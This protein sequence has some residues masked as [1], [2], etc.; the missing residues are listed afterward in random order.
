MRHEDSP[1]NI[2]ATD[3]LR[4]AAEGAAQAWQAAAALQRGDSAPA[5]LLLRGWRCSDRPELRGAL[6]GQLEA[7]PPR[8]Q[9]RPRALLHGPLPALEG[10]RRPA[11]LWRE[12]LLNRLPEL[13]PATDP[14]ERLAWGLAELGWWGGQVSLRERELWRE[15][16]FAPDAEA[17]LRTERLWRQ[18]LSGKLWEARAD[19]EELLLPE[20]MSAFRAALAAR[21]VPLAERAGLLRDFED[22][23][24]WYIIGGR[25][26]LPGWKELALRLLEMR[27]E[28]AI[29]GVA[30]QL[31]R[32]GLAWTFACEGA[33]TPSWREVARALPDLPLGRLGRLR[34]LLRQAEQD[35]GWL[36]RLLDLK[37]CLR[38]LAA[39]SEEAPRLGMAQAWAVVL[40]HRSRTRGRLRAVLGETSAEAL[41][42]GLIPR[43][44]LRHRTA[45]ALR[46]YAWGRAHESLRGHE[47]PDWSEG[48]TPRCEAPPAL[49]EPI[50]TPQRSALVT[51]VL[52]VCLRDRLDQ[53]LHWSRSGRWLRR[54]DSGWGRLLAEQLPADMQDRGGGYERLRLALHHEL[55]SALAELR[56]R[57]ARL[58]ALRGRPEARTATMEI[59]A[60]GWDPA[61]PRIQRFQR[62]L[63]EAAARSWELCPEEASDEP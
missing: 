29:D 48:L 10:P 37:V 12:E 21:R 8:P 5:E 49:P 22:T 51:W 44:G 56:P 62:E 50:G 7:R 11:F 47:L 17:D 55:Q 14:T 16:S 36:E 58:A 3:F 26:E 39:W 53:L 42:L 1:Q 6:L 57:L 31:G 45:L 28:S 23:L 61:V 4:E 25:D 41:E 20:A 30:A 9:G 35:P 27:G 15:R 33:W 19:F 32:Q 59:L 13:P 43:A 18:L 24:Y 46:Q 2:D 38:L 52:L 40:H 34:A 54:P 63:L 60:E